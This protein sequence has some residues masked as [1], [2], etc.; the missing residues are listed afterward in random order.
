MRWPVRAFV[1]TALLLVGT[2]ALASAQ[3]QNSDCGDAS[4][5]AELTE[6]LKPGFLSTDSVYVEYR[7]ANG[8]Q[9]LD[10]TAVMGGL[11]DSSLCAT[12]SA[13]LHN[14]MRGWRGWTNVW[15]TI[16]W[17]EDYLQFGPYYVVLVSEVP[18]AGTVGQRWELVMWD[19]QT[20]TPLPMRMKF[21][22]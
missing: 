1:G 2:A 15:S 20:L 8:L 13:A 3:R 14:Q 18:P 16:P 22:D 5:A 10:S 6:W 7:A 17:T 9:Q 12:L 11:T 4:D 19:A 21:I